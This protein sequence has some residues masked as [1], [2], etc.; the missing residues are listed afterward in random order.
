[1]ATGSRFLEALLR[2]PI[3]SGPSYTAVG[4]LRDTVV[5][6]QP[7]VNRLAAG[8]AVQIQ[9]VCPGRAFAGGL[10]HIYLAADAV[11]FALAVDALDHPG[12][13]DPA[14]IDPATCLLQVLPGADLAA[15]G[16]LGPGLVQAAGAA[17]PTVAA[18][19]PLRCPLADGCDR[20]SAAVL[21]TSV[22][23]GAGVPV[24]VSA[25]EG[26]RVRLRLG[27]RALRSVVVG[28]GTTRVRLPLTACRRC[29][30]PEP[31]TCRATV[32]LRPRGARAFTALVRSRLR[33]R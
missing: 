13:A 29:R 27:D 15:L 5:T 22:R 31:G 18:E 30:P 9:D 26:G 12:A 10:D 25:P 1:V 21:R 16:R 33:V 24:R 3:P 19:P 32:E 8:R 28:V 23:R 17:G 11:G 7:E 6:P 4:T 14:R 20:P 2:R